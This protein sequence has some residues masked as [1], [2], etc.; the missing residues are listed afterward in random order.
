MRPVC[1]KR[2]VEARDGE[3]LTGMEVGPTQAATRLAY[4]VHSRNVSRG[5]VTTP[6][7]A[8]PL[9]TSQATGRLGRVC[10][11]VPPVGD[12]VSVTGCRHEAR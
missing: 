8:R 11:E 3:V 1:A 4:D 5:R 9:P 6:A 10:L 7:S 2:P 12:R